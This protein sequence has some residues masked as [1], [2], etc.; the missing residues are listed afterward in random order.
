MS[1]GVKSF[2]KNCL[3]AC[4]T[5]LLC[6]VPAADAQDQSSGIHDQRVI[7]EAQ[8]RLQTNV[9]YKCRDMSIDLVLDQLSDQ[10]DIDI[11]KS[12]KVIGNVTV[13]VT[14]VPLDEALKIILEVHGWT[15]IP[16]ENMI[17]VIPIDEVE[18]AATRLGTQIYQITYADVTEVASALKEFIKD[19]GSIAVNK[20]TSNIIVTAN[21]NMIKSINQ[22]VEEIDRITQQVLVEV[23]IYDVTSTGRLDIGIDWN[24]GRTT[25]FGESSEDSVPF[26]G[27]DEARPLTGGAHEPY[28]KASFSGATT[29]T[30]AAEGTLDIGILNSH[31][32]VRAILHL[33]EEVVSATLLANPRVLVLNNETATFKSVSEFPYVDESQSS[34]GGSLT[35]IQ[36]KEVGVELD[37]TPHIARDG[38]IRIK[39][40][41]SFSVKVGEVSGVPVVDSREANTVTLVR[42]GQTVVLGGLRKKESTKQINKIP[43]LGDLPLIGGLF[44]SEGEQEITNELVVFITPRIIDEPVLSDIEASQLTEMS[45]PA[46]EI[47]ETKEYHLD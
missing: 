24:A 19:Q 38:M 46:P 23:Q 8:R 42:D 37:V 14:D 36:F 33:Q 21:E 18:V 5:A 20:G 41:P 26:L 29:F 40:T 15:Y 7:T 44:R 43:L 1:I 27:S 22:F 2:S 39:I 11:I 12:P 10:A 6:L 13:K 16:S 34:Y 17:K 9:S 47:T 3:L 28:G 25:T 35:T 31:I 32:N 30:E 45:F 4:V